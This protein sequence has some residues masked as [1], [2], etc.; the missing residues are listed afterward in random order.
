M[1]QVSQKLPNQ[2]QNEP[3]NNTSKNKLL[4]FKDEFKELVEKAEFLEAQTQ[5]RATE[6]ESKSHDIKV[7]DETLNVKR[8]MLEGVNSSLERAELRLKEVERLIKLHGEEKANLLVDL[9]RVRDNMKRTLAEAKKKAA[10]Q[11]FELT[12]EL[13]EQND[14]VRERADFFVEQE[15]IRLE[16]IEVLTEEASKLELTVKLLTDTVQHLSNERDGLGIT[17]S[18]LRFRVAEEINK[19]DAALEKQKEIVDLE[20]REKHTLEMEEKAKVAEQKLVQL[21]AK[22]QSLISREDALRGRAE[23]LTIRE[24]RLDSKERLYIV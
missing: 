19:L 1:S 11:K 7:L 9:R 12:V 3:S 6:L 24:R 10:A 13:K 18:D 2:T 21:K 5:E 4:E 16:A 20:S 8:N 23:E 15:R 17:L 14:K 22:E